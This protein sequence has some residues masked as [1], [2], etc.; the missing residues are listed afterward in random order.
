MPTAQRSPGKSSSRRRWIGW[1]VL[2]VA[3][4]G[5]AWFAT[6][7]L[8]AAGLTGIH[9]TFTVKECTEEAGTRKNPHTNEF[10]CEGTFRPDD[11]ST[12]DD[13]VS[14]YAFS[15]DYDAGTKLPA[16]HVDGGMVGAMTSGYLLA[17]EDGISGSFLKAFLCLLCIPVLLFCRLTGFGTDGVSI[18]LFRES[19]RATK[20]TRTRTIVVTALAVVLFCA[21]EGSNILAMVLPGL[22]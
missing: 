20:G 11:G 13:G 15:T 2:V 17:N 10:D 9:G 12:V 21:I 7:G 22:V 16:Q 5:S 14:L 8:T 19:W 4:L 3:L 18:Q 6:E 1:S